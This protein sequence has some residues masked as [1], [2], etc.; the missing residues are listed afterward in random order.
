[1]LIGT[2]GLFEVVCE[3]D[4]M[5]SVQLVQGFP[6]D[7]FIYAMEKDLSGMIWI[8]TDEGLY[9]F[10][11]NSR[12]ATA[13]GIAEN[14]QLQ[15]FNSNGLFRSST[16]WMYAGGKSGM[17]YFDPEQLPVTAFPIRPILASFSIGG[18]DSIFFQ[19]APP[20]ITSYANRQITAEVSV[21]DFSKPY[22][23]Q[24]RYRTHPGEPWV[25][26]GSSRFIQLHHYAPGRYQLEVAASH[27]GVTWQSTT[28]P[29]EFVILSPWW[30]RWYV[31]TA[32]LLVFLGLGY[33]LWRL[34]QKQRFRNNQQAAIDYFAR[35]GDENT[36][37]EYILWD[38]AMN[39]ISRLGFEEC[40]IYLVDHERNTL[41]QKAAYGPKSNRQF[42]I[43]NP[44]EIP[45]GKGITGYVANTGVAE[46]VSDTVLDPRY[47]VDDQVRRSEIT[48]PIMFEDRVI[49]IID[50]EHRRKNF[51]T[52]DHLQTLEIIAGICSVKIAREMSVAEIRKAE[53]L[54]RELNNRMLEAKFQNLRLQM[55]PH[56]L[57]NTLSSIQH[58]VVSKQTHEAY[59]YLS[60]FSHFLRS[61]LQYA[62]K[63]VITLDDELSMLN[64]YV[65]LE[66]LGSDKTFTF[67]ID[68]D[69]SLD[70][71]DVLIPPLM[72]QPIIENAI[73][74][75]LMPKEG[76]RYL[77]VTFVNEN[78]THLICTV[79]DDG[80]GRQPRGEAQKL[81]DDFTYQSKGMSLITDRLALLQQKTGK[82]A[83]MEIVDK[84]QQSR[85]SG[86]CVRLILP[87]YNPGE[88]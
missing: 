68:V 79:D 34:Y 6:A 21:P 69:D 64:M 55:N 73:W 20:Y 11:L 19:Q 61:A 25:S 12:T 43:N 47:V 52:Q 27:D 60:V 75:G 87:F 32:G 35:S 72:I 53:A 3:G 77:Q 24:Y 82:P 67:H 50:S 16:G 71:E 51:F 31:D 48:V 42:E 4:T 23:L 66:Q 1:M 46:I 76:D 9:R 7:R 18:N 13:F 80:I 10:D 40:V 15:A 36:S 88:V 70:T 22:A 38:I 58:L 14:V 85:P 57:F 26:N 5:A 78:D 74:H 84:Q 65:Q 28:K 30:K 45:I 49:G 56:F 39:C 83:S 2:R 17:N 8:G 29:V 33:G 44:I 63:N 86:T 41:V 81:F 62:D 37:V 54:M 59:T